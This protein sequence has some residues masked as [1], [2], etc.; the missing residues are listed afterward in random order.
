MQRIPFFN[1]KREFFNLLGN[2]FDYVTLKAFILTKG[3]RK[4]SFY[5]SFSFQTEHEEEKMTL[6]SNG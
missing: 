5:G 1:I 6:N 3:M 4:Q 2:Q